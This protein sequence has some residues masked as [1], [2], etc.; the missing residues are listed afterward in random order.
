MPKKFTYK[1]KAIEELEKMP[2]KDLML[3]LPARQRRSLKRGLTEIEKRFLSKVEKAKKGIYKKQIKTHAR[4]MIVLPVMVGLNIGIYNG[5]E[6][7]SVMMQPEMIGHLLG[8]FAITR[9][10]VEHSAP[11]LGA[12]KSSSAIAVK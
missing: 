7:V 6:F 4:D 12:T 2:I 5:K 9:K 1:G 11:G 10:K 8:E 3:I